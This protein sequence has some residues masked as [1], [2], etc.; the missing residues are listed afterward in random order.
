MHSNPLPN[1]PHCSRPI[2]FNY[3][4]DVFKRED[5]TPCGKIVQLAEEVASPPADGA[6]PA[7]IRRHILAMLELQR[8][9]AAWAGSKGAANLA[10]Q[11]RG[12]W[13]REGG[14]RVAQ[15]ACKERSSGRVR[16]EL[17]LLARL[18]HCS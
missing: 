13:R 5:G 9:L 3:P 12:G 18:T 7:A 11:V 2:T 4:Q 8:E 16:V 10:E 1:L 17:V 6:A 14:E 15:L